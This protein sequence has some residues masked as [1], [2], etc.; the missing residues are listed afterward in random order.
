MTIIDDT[1]ELAARAT[2]SER[3]AAMCLDLPPVP[4]PV[5]AYVPAV[6]T[7]SWV[8]TSGQLPLVGGVLPLSGKVGTDFTVT[9][10]TPV[11]WILNGK[12]N[13]P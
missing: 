12:R 1:I 8:W 11:G 7:G 4:Q 9:G 2:P 6:R 10:Y 5:A 13:F 3:L